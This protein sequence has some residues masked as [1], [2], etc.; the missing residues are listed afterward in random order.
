[1][2]EHT[3]CTINSN[4]ARP[5]STVWQF[6]I[7]FCVICAFSFFAQQAYLYCLYV[8][9]SVFIS[10]FMVLFQQKHMYFSFYHSLRWK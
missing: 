8:K 3:D 9:F 1:M 5:L 4:L 10:A 7:L 2:L 6:F